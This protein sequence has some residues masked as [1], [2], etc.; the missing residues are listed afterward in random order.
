MKFF[1]GLKYALLPSLL[2]WAIIIWVVK[3]LVF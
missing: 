3:E 1:K 2:L